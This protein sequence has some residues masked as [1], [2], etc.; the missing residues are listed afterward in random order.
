MERRSVFIERS[1]AAQYA[2]SDE[3]EDGYDSP[4]VKRRGASVDDF[5]KGSELG[6]QVSNSSC[7]C[8]RC[9]AW[10]KC[11][12]RFSKLCRPPSDYCSRTG[13]L[14]RQT[15]KLW[16]GGWMSCYWNIT[17]SNGNWMLG[18]VHL[19]TVIPSSSLTH[20]KIKKTEPEKNGD[21]KC[22][23]NVMFELWDFLQDVL[24]LHRK[25]S[26]EKEWE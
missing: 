4:N 6:K 5:L 16:A 22:G 14:Y 7:Y 24:L 1:N 10:N 25:T 3:E 2:N 20:W 19:E 11:S 26:C 18:A 21:G 13:K 8:V 12:M 15:A 23:C 17:R 9:W